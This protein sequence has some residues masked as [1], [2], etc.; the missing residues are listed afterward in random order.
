MRPLALTAGQWDVLI[1]AVGLAGI[2]LLAIPAFYANRYGRL[3]ARI[4]QDEPT[5]PDLKAKHDQL[6]KELKELQENWTPCK[7]NAL[8]LGTLLTGLSNL[9]GLIKGIVL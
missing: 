3:L 8:I 6:T 1:N 2:L 7:G 5:S 9:L 4:G